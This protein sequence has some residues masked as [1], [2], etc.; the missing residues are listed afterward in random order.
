MA[1]W[2]ALLGLLVLTGAQCAVAAPGGD[3]GILEYWRVDFVLDDAASP[4]G[5]DAPWRGVALPDRWTDPERWSGALIGWYRLRLPDGPAPAVPWAVY[6]WRFDMAAEVWFNGERVSS[7]GR[8]TEPVTR[9]WNRPRL[10]TLPASGWRASGNRVHVRLRGYPRYGALAPVFVGPRTLLEPAYRW[11]TFLQEDLSAA[12]LVLTLV[13]AVV[14]FAFWMPRK[15]DTVYLWFALASLAY[16]VFSLNMVVRDVPV[17][18]ETWWW[19]THAAI[20]WWVV[21]LAMF[22][23]RLVGIVRPRLER[24]L[25]IYAAGATLVMA[26]VDLPT[27]A[28]VANLLHLVGLS[29]AMY[30]AVLLLGRWRRTRRTDLG[31]FAIGMV[32]ILALALHDMLMSLV[33]HEIMWRYGFFLLNLGAPPVF[34]ALLWHLTRRY[35]EALSQAEASN[36]TLEIRVADARSALDASYAERRDLEV[37][38]A[39]ASERERIYRDLHDDVGARLLS[40]VYA[41]RDEV[42]R[43]LARDTLRELRE[44]VAHAAIEPSG[45]GDLAE[46]IA[47]E[48][49][50]RAAAAGFD[51]DVEIDV[52]ADRRLQAVSVWHLSRIAREAVSNALRHSG[53][54]RLHL[55]IAEENGAL[56][57]EVEDDG[58]GF[59]DAPAAGRGIGNIRTRAAELGG[60]VEFADAGGRGCRMRLRVPVARLEATVGC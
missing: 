9:D 7:G 16:S 14:G 17:S 36:R 2:F 32:L 53:G 11:R 33:A 34:L 35:V 45:L 52:A 40:L 27:F 56:L 1:R 24:A 55:R 58:A 60:A 3:D 25:L 15:S 38:Q 30:L 41:A 31:V 19:I 43:A 51:A 28:V 37:A 47:D 39:A 5:E 29:V 48:M 22:A 46:A 57:L 20:E 10:V 42:Q 26:A 23:H 44:I 54:S 6:L 8:F 59:A 21:M 50:E 12:L 13:I 18:G 4:P 49:R